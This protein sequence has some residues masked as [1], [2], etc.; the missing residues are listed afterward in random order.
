M[1]G[2]LLFGPCILFDFHVLYFVIFLKN[3]YLF[4]LCPVKDMGKDKPLT[5]GT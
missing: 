1:F 3:I 5:G 2:T 4:S